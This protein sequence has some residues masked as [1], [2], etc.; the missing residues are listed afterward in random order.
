MYI[1]VRT[2]KRHFLWCYFFF[3]LAVSFSSHLT[4]RKEPVGPVL[5]PVRS[6]KRQLMLA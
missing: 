6:T 1:F 2:S 4:R 5:L 3:V